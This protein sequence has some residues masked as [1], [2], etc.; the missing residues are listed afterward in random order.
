MALKKVTSLRD[1]KILAGTDPQYA[2]LAMIA[3]SNLG[4]QCSTVADAI[5]WLSTNADETDEKGVVKEINFCRNLVKTKRGKNPADTWQERD[6]I[7]TK[8][9]VMTKRLLTKKLIATRK[10]LLKMGHDAKMARRIIQQV[11]YN[12]IGS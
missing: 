8:G 3:A 6:K 2:E 5:A 10:K 7:T 4:R 9:L 11:I 12:A 1:L